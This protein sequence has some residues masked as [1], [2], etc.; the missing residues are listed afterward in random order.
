MFKQTAPSP[1]NDLHRQ[2]ICNSKHISKGNVSAGWMMFRDNVH[3]TER[4]TVLLCRTGLAL[5]VVGVDGGLAMFW[6]G[7]E[8]D[9]V[10]G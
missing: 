7:L 4:N 9:H 10:G 2:L 1:T 8:K 6:A 5:E 3:L